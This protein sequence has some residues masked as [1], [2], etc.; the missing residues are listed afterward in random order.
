MAEKTNHESFDEATRNLYNNCYNGNIKSV[1]ELIEQHVNIYKPQNDFMTPLQVAIFKNKLVIVNLLLDIYERDLEALNGT[2]FTRALIAMPEDQ[3]EELLKT[4]EED[5]V[6]G[7]IPVLIK[8]NNSEKS[9]CV[10]L[11]N[12]LKSKNDSSLRLAKTLERKNGWCDIN[13][14]NIRSYGT[15][16]AL[17]YVLKENMIQ[18]VDRLLK[19]PSIDKN[20]IDFGGQTPLHFAVLRGYFKAFEAIY[21]KSDIKNDISFLYL[22][23]QSKDMKMMELVVQKML[24]NGKYSLKEICRMIV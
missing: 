16:P 1:N 10:F 17:H 11:R 20:I 6:D 2:K 7:F 22:V 18:I 5:P 13:W 8:I 9:K 14:Q 12:K 23:V 15:G 21:R 4:V 19:I 24:E 3:T